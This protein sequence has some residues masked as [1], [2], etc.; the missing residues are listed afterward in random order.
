MSWD[1]SQVVLSPTPFLP[2]IPLYHSHM[3][4]AE[5]SANIQLGGKDRPSET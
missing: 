3:I 5:V 4:W 1:C 2:H